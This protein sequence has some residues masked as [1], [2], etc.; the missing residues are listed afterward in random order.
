MING[1]GIQ[2][3]EKDA[4]FIKFIRSISEKT[5]NYMEQKAVSPECHIMSCP[6]MRERRKHTRYRVDD[7]KFNLKIDL[8]KISN[9]I[10]ISISGISLIA[11]RR[12][13]IGKQYRLKFYDGRDVIT[14]NGTVIWS[15]LS[16]SRKVLKGHAV[17]VYT[18]GMKF[19][20]ISNKTIQE[21]MHLIDKYKK[22]DSALNIVPPEN[23]F[24]DSFP[25]NV[26]TDIR[27]KHLKVAHDLNDLYNQNDLVDL[28]VY[29]KDELKEFGKSHECIQEEEP[30]DLRKKSIA[31]K[32]TA[33]LFCGKEERS[34]LLKDPHKEVVLAVLD[35]PKITITEIEEIAKMHSVPEEA[36]KKIVQKRE[37][38]KK[39]GV[40]LSL[41][42]N[43]KTPAHISIKLIKNIKVKDL[44]IISRSKEV[45]EAIRNVAQK[46]YRAASSHRR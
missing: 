40:V 36:I 18:V 22:T 37:W 5:K 7:S 43:P 30:K 27:D 29:L 14:V 11:D 9:I 15:L 28:S 34:V 42:T 41:V 12:L 25:E 20:N 19:T 46:A 2:L 13:D 24:A 23:E 33:A 45:P 21:L 32:R 17:P 4:Q 6:T 35:N 16:E 10:D 26:T 39:Y 8:T 3:T 44:K 31:E 1:I 38:M